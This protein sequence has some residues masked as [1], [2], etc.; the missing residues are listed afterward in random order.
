M[1][2]L[3]EMIG[4]IAHQWRQPL[5]YI[6]TA[7]SGMKVQKEF[8]QLSD[9][10]FIKLVDGITD[11]TM[12]LSQTID[13]FRDYIKSEKIKKEF[14]IKNCIER[15]LSL[16]D[17]AFKNHHILVDT[18][19]EDITIIGFEN[20][21]NQVLLNLLSNSKDALKDIEQK[22]RRVFINSFKKDNTLQIEVIDSGGGIKEDVIKKVFEPYFSTK[23]KSQGTGLG[24]YM[25]HNIIT[26]SMNGEIKIQNISYKNYSKC[27]KVTII[28]PL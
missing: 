15:V 23:H 18:Q 12:F 7:A 19:I 20:E 13:D 3:G 8:G 1:A 2:S 17:G 10:Q 26:K 28:L 14:L 16:M 27:T 9:E 25:T 11:T 6:S 22:N 4:N 5:S 21:L 24:L